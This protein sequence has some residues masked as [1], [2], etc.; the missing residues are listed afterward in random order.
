M[1]QKEWTKVPRTCHPRKDY[2]FVQ[3]RVLLLQ[4]NDRELIERHRKLIR[5]NLPKMQIPFFDSMMSC[6]RRRIRTDHKYLREICRIQSNEYE[7]C[8]YSLRIKNLSYTFGDFWNNYYKM[9]LSRIVPAE[10]IEI[11]DIYDEALSVIEENE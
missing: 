9:I 2:E 6:M 10:E 1:T 5:K 3:T 7:Q 11:D 8:A 4:H